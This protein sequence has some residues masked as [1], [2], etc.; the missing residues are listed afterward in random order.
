MLFDRS[1]PLITTFALV[2]D[3]SVTTL[4]ETLMSTAIKI[5][6]VLDEFINFRSVNVLASCFN[7]NCL[8][9]EAIAIVGSMFQPTCKPQASF[10][11]FKLVGSA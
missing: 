11:S 7:P 8:F 5:V 6:P 9:L 2:T 4:S 1:N 10:E 3:L